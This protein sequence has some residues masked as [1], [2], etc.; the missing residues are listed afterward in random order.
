MSTGVRGAVVYRMFI[1]QLPDENGTIF[2]SK[3][4]CSSVCPHLVILAV[5]YSNTSSVV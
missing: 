1:Q 2:I 5:F 4:E 3:D